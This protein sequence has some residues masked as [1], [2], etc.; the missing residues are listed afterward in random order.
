MCCERLL[1]KSASLLLVVCI[2]GDCACMY[3][4][5]LIHTTFRFTKKSQAVPSRSEVVSWGKKY[6]SSRK[7]VSSRSSLSTML[8]NVLLCRVD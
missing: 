4:K 5:R 1:A 6:G 8:G 7:G 3:V 2:A